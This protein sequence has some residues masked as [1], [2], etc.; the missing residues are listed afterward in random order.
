MP[1]RK[2]RL[3]MESFFPPP[4]QEDLSDINE[5]T[6]PRPHNMGEITRNEIARAILKPSSKK[7]PGL[8]DIPSLVLQ[9][10]IDVMLSIYEK[11]FNRCLKT[12]FC[13]QHF[14]DS[15]TVALRKPGK[16]DY[17]TSKAW[18]PIALLNTIG[19]VMESVIATRIPYLAE[20]HKLLSDT[21]MGGRK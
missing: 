18:R 2:A 4:V 10:T 12:G 17:T 7:A 21:H 19:R 20:E 13:P 9:K 11:L 6:Y 16:G 5:N 15:I 1:K 14:R 3:L 8:D